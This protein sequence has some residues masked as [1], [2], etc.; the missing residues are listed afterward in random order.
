MKCWILFFLPFSLLA[1]PPRHIP[2]EFYDAFTENQTIEV[3]DFYV[4]ESEPTVGKRLY[5]KVEVDALMQKAH[6]KEAYYYG[7]TDV[8][9]FELL[10]SYPEL[11]QGKDV[12]VMG[13][14]VPW[15]EAIVLAYGGRPW[16][17]EYNPID[18]DDSRLTLLTVE[19]FSQNP[20]KFGVIFSISSFEHDGLGRYG[21]PIDPE[22]DMK[23]MQNCLSM[24]NPDGFMVFATQIGKGSI[25]WN[26]HRIYG[27]ARLSRLLEGWE[28]L[29]F[30]GD[31]RNMFTYEDPTLWYQPVFLL[32][33]NPN[34]PKP[35]DKYFDKTGARR[36]P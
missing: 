25:C 35:F 16:T 23:A 21:D 15:Y 4:D 5:T 31:F 1:K 36:V 11:L 10:D 18:T 3:V 28:L 32:E 2:E 29:D 7:H 20:R 14:T 17:I 26:A 30:R 13:S 22:G 27:R 9:L 24:L 34:G 19:E 33:P 8:W 6:R 12:A